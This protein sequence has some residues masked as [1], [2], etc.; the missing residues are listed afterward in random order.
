MNQNDA[1]DAGRRK[2]LKTGATVAALGAVA[3][4]GLFAPRAVRAEE[5]AS[6]DAMMYQPTPHGKETCANCIHYIP[7][8][9]PKAD[10]TCNVVAGAVAPQAWCVAYAAK[11]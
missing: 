10:G 2:W 8:K 4:T 7:G 11:G 5:K 6:K 1:F 9:N 3:A